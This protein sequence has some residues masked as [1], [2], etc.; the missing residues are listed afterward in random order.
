[1]SQLDDFLN[2]FGESELPALYSTVRAISQIAEDSG[3]HIEKLAEII[4]R[5]ASMT[6]HILSIPKVLIEFH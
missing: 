6:A 2:K 3:V 1:M 4:G 5:D